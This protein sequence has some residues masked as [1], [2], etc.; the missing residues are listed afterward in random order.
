MKQKKSAS[1]VKVILSMEWVEG[2]RR[3]PTLRLGWQKVPVGI[4]CSIGDY[5]CTTGKQIFR[6]GSHDKVVLTVVLYKCVPN[7]ALH[8]IR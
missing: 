6:C 7:S 2:R 3:K 5:F 8:W 4:I 1:L